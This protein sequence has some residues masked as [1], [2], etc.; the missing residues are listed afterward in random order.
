MFGAVSS[1]RGTYVIMGAWSRAV[2]HIMWKRVLYV[3]VC[4][5]CEQRA[6]MRLVLSHVR[7]VS[8]GRV[9]GVL[10]AAMLRQDSASAA[11][12]AFFPGLSDVECPFLLARHF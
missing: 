4:L 7:A 12:T 6:R 8:H 10:P 11:T 1:P 2:F 5:R 9:F 3:F